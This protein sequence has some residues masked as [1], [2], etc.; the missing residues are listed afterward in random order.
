M[1]PNKYKF[2]KKA[3]KLQLHMQDARNYIQV[4]ETFGKQSTF[5]TA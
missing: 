3:E 5:T 4:V 1:N 2:S